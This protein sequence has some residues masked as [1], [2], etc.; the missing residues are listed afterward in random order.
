ME[1]AASMVEGLTR[2]ARTSTAAI[3]AA[4]ILLGTVAPA[5]TVA[6]TGG[7]EGIGVIRATG[8]DGAGALALVGRIGVGDIRMA[9]T[10][11]AR[12]ITVLRIPTIIRTLV[13]RAIHVLPTGMMTLRH[14]IRTQNPEAIQQSL[15]GRR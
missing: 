15:G 13:L 8:M 14:L 10:A 1:E 6:I 9:T 2:V 5:G 12:G 3:M 4:Q 7:M 11:T